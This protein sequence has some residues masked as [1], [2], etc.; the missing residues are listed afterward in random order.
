MPIRSLL[1]LLVL[2]LIALCSRI[3]CAEEEAATAADAASSEATATPLPDDQTLRKMKVSQ[4]KAL[5]AKKGPDAA[6]LAC[7]SRIEYV[8]RIRETADWPDV[9]PS[10]AASDPTKEEL[11]R[12]FANQKDMP[13]MEELKRK[14][15]EAGLDTSNIYTAD[16]IGKMGGFKKGGRK[17]KNG[18]K[19]DANVDAPSDSANADDNVQSEL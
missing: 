12:M 9:T 13:N 1:L 8:E 2:G 17:A 3:T 6:C 10:P 11:D 19:A 15:K 14:L 7:T 16:D 18:A 4:L 5:L